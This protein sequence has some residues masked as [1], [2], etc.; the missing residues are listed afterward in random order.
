MG[1]RLR[2]LQIR[3]ETT[4]GPYGFAIGFANGMTVIRADNS[5]GKSTC[6]MAILYGLGLEGMLGPSHQPPFA[7]VMTESLLDG[8]QAWEV[9]ES[10]VRVEIENDEGER[11]TCKRFVIR[12]SDIDSLRVRQLIRV[13]EGG[14]ISNPDGDVRSK[15]YFVRI[16]NAAQSDSGFHYR[17][18]NFLGYTLPSVPGTEQ[19]QVSLYLETLFPFF[20]VDQLSGWRDVKARMPTYLRIPEMAKRATEYILNLDIL[21]REIQRQSLAQREE[22]LR[23]RWRNRLVVAQSEVQGKS[24][25]LQGVPETPAD[26]WPP[27]NAT[28]QIMYTDGNTWL[29]VDIAIKRIEQRLRELSE[30]ALESTVTHSTG[31]EDQERNYLLLR[32]AENRLADVRE[33]VLLMGEKNRL[34]ELNIRAVDQRLNTL[35]DELSDYRETKKILDRGGFSE[36]KTAQGVCPTCRQ[37]MKDTL[38]PQTTPNAPMSLDDNIDYIKDEFDAYELMRRQALTATQ[39]RQVVL[40]QLRSREL[41]LTQTIREYR[42]TLVAPLGTPSAAKIGEQL[43]LEHEIDRLNEIGAWYEKLVD[44][45]TTMSK[46]MA[47]IKRDRKS[48]GEDVISTSDHAKIRRLTDA[49]RE[50]LTLY[51]FRSFRV[52][53][54]GI[55]SATYR[56]VRHEL[57]VG[58]TSASD[59]VRLIWAYLLSMLEVARCREFTTNHLGLLVFDEP[60]Q[61]LFLLLFVSPTRVFPAR[62]DGNTDF[63]PRVRVRDVQGAKQSGLPDRANA[64]PEAARARRAMG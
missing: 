59:A 58:L 16:A 4:N 6:M 38:L 40:S 37:P 61:A 15:D 56:P 54:I 52:E 51:G 9:I 48:L 32:E 2:N 33:Q 24:V 3:I 31:S 17:L 29:S 35:S 1:M 36:L 57:D 21:N 13:D 62:S 18:A 53:E 41:E 19:G 26:R 30:P 55:S 43:R 46:E 12:Q 34:E 44:E 23:Q 28:P 45:M 64:E 25:V 8:Q 10:F 63:P 42:R 49:F 7:E 5:S 39:S 60:K 20:F 47:D 50:Q 14:T 22:T 11:M 27:K